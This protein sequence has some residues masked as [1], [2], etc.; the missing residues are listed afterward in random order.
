MVV[1]VA[2]GGV[3]GDVGV[4]VVFGVVVGDGGVECGDG[5]EKVRENH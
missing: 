3:A 4:G 2:G 5:A 1:V